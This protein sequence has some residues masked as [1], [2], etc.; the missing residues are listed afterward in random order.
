MQPNTLVDCKKTLFLSHPKKFQLIKLLSTEL[1]TMGFISII[2]EGDADAE[3]AREAYDFAKE[4][5]VVLKTNSTASMLLLCELI[6]KNQIA[7]GE[8]HF[9]LENIYLER[10]NVIYDCSDLVRKILLLLQSS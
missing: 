8:N 3:M 7:H 1:R 6:Y 10:T 2:C 4:K 9:H 5:D